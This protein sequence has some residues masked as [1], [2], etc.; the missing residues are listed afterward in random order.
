MTLVNWLTLPVSLSL[1][2]FF[3]FIGYFVYTLIKEYIIEYKG[4]T[5]NGKKNL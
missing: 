5:S 4:R 1:G 2:A 3:I